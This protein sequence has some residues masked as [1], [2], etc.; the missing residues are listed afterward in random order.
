MSEPEEIEITED[1]RYSIDGNEIYL[2]SHYPA[3]FG[4][5]VIE[6][7]ELDELISALQKIKSLQS[8]SRP[9]P[10]A[11]DTATPIEPQC[12][13]CGDIYRQCACDY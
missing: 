1:L 6:F 10:L 8:K 12:P 9:T 7:G 3:E 11:P 4:D 5:I 2:Y 13:V